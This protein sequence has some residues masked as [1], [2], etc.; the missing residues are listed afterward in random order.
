MTSVLV[1][2]DEHALREEIIDILQFEGYTVIGAENGRRGI[3]AALQHQPDIILCDIMM[4]EFDGYRVLLEL[5][6]NQSTAM[7]PFI[8]MTARADRQD[9]RKGMSLGADDYITKPFTHSE[10]L[11]AVHTRLEKQ[12]RLKQEA[13][14]AVNS[15]RQRLVSSLPHEMRTPLVGIL[16]FAELMA[17]DADNLTP[18]QIRS[19]TSGIISGGERLH[20]TI[21]NYLLFA[22]LEGLVADP[23]KGISH[24]PGTS[25]PG[26]LAQFIAHDMASRHEREGDLRL[27]SLVNA[28]V[29]IGETTLRKITEELVDNAFK[30]SKPGSAVE[31][32]GQ[33]QNG[34]YRLSVQDHGRG[35]TPEQSR[36]IAAFNQFDR[37]QYEQQGCGLGLAITQR[38]L[39]LF[40]SKLEIQ[41]VPNAGTLVTAVI[42]RS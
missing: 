10:M 2:D 7:T 15:L 20:H 28:P 26:T 3:E 4:P 36:H 35:M 6:V 9:I 40:N 42:K 12:E 14:T 39:E 18:D 11:S 33:V 24:E 23:V 25:T 8:F 17:M 16:G 21:E 27:G 41:S 29:T 30:F 32:C 38:L 13:E 34:H 5:K 31:I 22:R 37:K 19:M 1:I